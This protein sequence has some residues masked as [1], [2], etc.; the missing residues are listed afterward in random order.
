MPAESPG[1]HRPGLRI[2]VV[3]DNRDAADSLAALLQLLG[4]PVTVAYDGPSGLRAAATDRPDCVFLDITMP[5]MNG[6]E[7][8]RRLRAELGRVKLI[9]L[10]AFSDPVHVERAA[11]AGFDHRLTKPAD[12]AE[13]EEL[14]TMLQRIKE[15][16]ETT[17]QLARQN[18]SLADETRSLLKEVKSDLK[19]VKEEVRELRDEVREIREDKE[20]EKGE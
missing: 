11:A 1:A 3:D 12:L 20:D 8:A 15:L 14:V 10:T 4:H 18:V 5:G 7:V 2:L 17:E 16:A 6:Y 9:A 19:E 13:L